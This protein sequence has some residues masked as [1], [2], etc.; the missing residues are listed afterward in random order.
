MKS[1]HNMQL[2]KKRISFLFIIVAIAGIFVLS[3]LFQLTILENGKYAEAAKKQHWSENEIQPKRGNIYVKDANEEFYPLATNIKLYKAFVDLANSENHDKTAENLSKILNISKDEITEKFKSSKS[4]RYIPIK[5]KITEDEAEKVRELKDKAIGLEPEHWRVYPEKD[6]ASQVL[7]Y[8]DGDGNGAGGIEQYFND[9]LKGVPGLYKAESDSLGNKI[10]TGRDVSTPAQD[11]EDVVLTINRDIQAQAELA[12]RKAVEKHHAKK[13]TVIVLDS[14]TGAIL[15]MANSPAYDPNSYHEVKDYSL[16]KNSA[17]SDIYE[18]GSIFKVLTMAAA[19]DARKIEPDT[20]FDDTGSV[21]LG[22]FT[23]KNSDLKAHGLVTMTQVLEQSLNTGT[24]HA[25]RLLGKDL[26]YDYLIKFGMGMITGIEAPDGTEGAGKVY[27][28]SEVNEHTYA[29]MSFGQSISTTPLQMATV[30]QAVA[31]NGKLVKP[32]LVEYKMKD[33]NK[34]GEYNQIEGKQVISPEAATKLT[35]M[36]VSVVQ[37]G[38][39]QQAGVKGYKVAGKTGTAQ[40]PK[41]DGLGYDPNKNIGS[42]IGFAPA[43]S[44]RFVVLAKID[45]PKG[46]SWAESTA[47][48][49]VGEVMQSLLNYYQIP[50][51]ESR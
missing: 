23:I 24:T 49:V 16:F 2:Q 38:H 42:F 11:G 1:Y 18:P 8:V 32:R 6:L 25:Q 48:P 10:L 45:E 34:T 44:P 35:G 28:P 33:G 40:V 27:K 20:K 26:F 30:F 9:E 14:R 4:K 19:L 15:A 13:G 41:E 22:G 12:L 47:A 37:R 17:I 21:T 5:R 39:G 46:V 51:T 3:R 7:G 36:M 29:T 31:N 50:P 43:D